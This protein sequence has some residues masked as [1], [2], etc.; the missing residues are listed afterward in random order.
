MTPEEKLRATILLSATDSGVKKRG[1]AL[2]WGG[3]LV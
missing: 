2:D 1:T 3:N